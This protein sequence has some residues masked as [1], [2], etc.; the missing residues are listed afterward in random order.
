M[1]KTFKFRL[2][3]SRQQVKIFNKVLNNCRCLYNA[4]L[5]YERFIYEKDR[6]F[7][8]RI[9]LNNI[10]PDLKIINPSLKQV[11][12]QILQNVNDRVI[13]SFKSFFNSIQRGQNVGYPRFKSGYR[14]NS[15][16]YPQI[17]FKISNG[18]LKLSKIGNVSIKLHRAIKGN[19][20]TLTI[21]R[22]STNK[23]FACFSVQ[24]KIT[25]QKRSLTKMIGI[26]LGLEHFATLSTGAVIDNPRCLKKSLELLKLRSRQL[27]KKKKGSANH[28]KTRIRLAKLHEKVFNQRLDFLHKV[29]PRLVTEYDGIALEDLKVS[30]MKNKYLQFSINDVAWNKFRQLLTYKAEEAG[31]K[32]DFRN[33]RYTSKRCSKCGMIQEMP[34][35]KRIYNCSCGNSL[36]RDLN[37]AFNILNQ[38]C[39]SIT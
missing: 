29:T 14:Y 36:S 19:I 1:R 6:R 28:Y 11:H 8:N 7:A 3:P 37:S 12:S 18:K 26:D 9:E 21:M 16:V 10:L 22:N 15:F 25:P 27:S 17:G 2:Y 31:C 30:S 20:K 34:L 32:L 33:P 5:E 23:W 35:S 39:F 4:Q 24:Q 13:K 38:S